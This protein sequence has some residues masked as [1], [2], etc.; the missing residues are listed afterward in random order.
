MTSFKALTTGAYGF[1]GASGD[2]Y[3]SATFDDVY[4]NDQGTVYDT[5][6]AALDNSLWNNFES[7]V[8]LENGRLR[9]NQQGTEVFL[10]RSQRNYLFIMN[11]HN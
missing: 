2:G 5:F 3:V 1:D 10:M 8:A 7:V 4:I 11:H 6:D 9:L